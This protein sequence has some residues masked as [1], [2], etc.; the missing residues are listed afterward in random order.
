MNYFAAWLLAVLPVLSGQASASCPLPSTYR[1][2]STGSLAQPAKGF[3]SLK[4]FSSTMYNNQHIVYATTITTGGGVQAMGFLPFNDWSDMATATQVEMKVGSVAPTIFYFAPKDIWVMGYEWCG[5][6]FCYVTAKDPTDPNGWSAPKTLYAGPFGIDETL[7]GDDTTMWLF[8][9]GDSGAIFRAS[10][11]IGDFPGSFGTK[12]DTIIKGDGHYVYEAVQVYT[13]QGQNQYLM[14]VEAWAPDN[15]RY[16]HSY[17]ATSLGGTWTPQATTQEEPFA[18]KANSGATWTDDISSGDL[19]RVK[20]DHTQTIDACNLQFLYQGRD[21]NSD[22]SNAAY[23]LRPYHPGLLTLQNPVL[24]A[25]G[26]PPSSPTSSALSKS[27]TTAASSPK[28]F[29]T[30]VRSSTTISTALSSTPSDP[31]D[32]TCS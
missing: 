6:P 23:S 18:G 26:L 3:I 7:I 31:P 5:D 21:P 24:P 32:E 16:F 11:P 20:N 1:W 29:T 22:G 17:T 12:Y 19:V 13:V 14:I 8:F 27:S 30:S 25:E 2:N 28:S 4:D 10:M 9:A 15:M